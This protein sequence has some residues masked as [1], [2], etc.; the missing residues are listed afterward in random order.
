MKIHRDYKVNL[1]YMKKLVEKLVVCWLAAKE[2]TEGVQ[3]GGGTF[4]SI[5]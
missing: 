1:C 3:L 5:K 2:N 4:P